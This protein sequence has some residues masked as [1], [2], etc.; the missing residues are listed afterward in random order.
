MPSVVERWVERL[1]RSYAA[2]SN[3]PGHPWFF[4]RRTRSRAVVS[5][6]SNKTA[7]PA[8]GSDRLSSDTLHPLVYR[9]MVGI[10][11][12]VVLAA[13]GFFADPG[14]IFLALTVVTWLVTV[15]VV[16]STVL[17]RISRCHPRHGQTNSALRNWTRADFEP[18]SGADRSGSHG[19]P[20]V[21][22][23]FTGASHYGPTSAGDNRGQ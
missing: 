11:V 3:L 18:M 10:G 2:I 16:L 15:A 12:W 23:G 5:A 19:I 1:D 21:H 13:W 6:M 22:L 4:D 7:L 20:A 8:E 14:Y 9:A 17:A